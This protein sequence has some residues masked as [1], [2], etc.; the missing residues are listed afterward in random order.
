M[1]VIVP[2]VV[3]TNIHRN[4]PFRQN[5]FVSLTFSPFIWYMMKHPEDGAQSAI[6]CTLAETLATVS[7]VLFKYVCF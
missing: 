3:R 5:A 2:G 4:M 1:N 7:G 6:Y